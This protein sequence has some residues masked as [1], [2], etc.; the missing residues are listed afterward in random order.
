MS[1][2]N[3]PQSGSG[4]IEGFVPG[5]LLEISVF[6]DQRLGESVGALDEFMNIPAFDTEFPL[7]HGIGLRRKSSR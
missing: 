7:I 3:F 5:D 1:F 4:E 2:F 6:A